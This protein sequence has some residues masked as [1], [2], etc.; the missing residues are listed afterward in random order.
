GLGTLVERSECQGDARL[1]VE[2]AEHG[3]LPAALGDSIAVSGVCLTA[4]TIEGRRFAADVST[5]TL[6]LT[7]LGE[8]AIGANVNLELPLCVGDPLGGHV[9]SGHV[10]G[11]GRL[12]S[13]R[14]DARS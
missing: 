7:T 1:V 13:M 9:V 12:E 14:E 6:S 2:S 4:T 5:E 10:D 8:I 3:P 11:L